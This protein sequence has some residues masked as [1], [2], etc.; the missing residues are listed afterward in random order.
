MTADPYKILGVSRTATADE[1]KQAFRR[2]ARQHHP[3]HNGGGKAAEERF[4]AVSIAHDLLSDPGKRAR[5][6]R[7]G[8][9]D[10]T[11][12]SSKKQRYHLEE[13]LCSGDLTDVH[14][15]RREADG[16]LVVLKIA[17]DPSVNDLVEREAKRLAHLFPLAADPNAPQVRYLPKF[18]ETF[19]ADDG[20]RRQVNV[21][22]FLANY[23]TCERLR[24]LTGGVAL[25]HGVWMFNRILEGLDYVHRCGFVHGALVPS[26]IMV[27]TDPKGHL[28]KLIDWG[29]AGKIHEP[30]VA[31]VPSY[32]D[33]Y[34]PE[35]AKKK[36]LGPETDLYMAAKML[37]YM[38]ADRMPD[39]LRTF[40]APC[41]RPEPTF[42]PHDAW[43][44]HESFKA[45]MH[46][47]YGPKKFVPFDNP[48]WAGS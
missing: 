45:H 30:A 19:K 27:W 10:P 22:D 21:L 41:L 48:A 5:Y 1:I 3:D 44:L 4:K 39:Y 34:P 7:L 9:T 40:L 20:K 13:L 31:M 11:V 8:T 29:Y 35:V 23:A 24:Q 36:P 15:A 28:V 18:W 6:D 32:G 37:V 46:R 16:R 14:R 43:A 33:F 12:L 38:L 47:H 2:L 26:H 17:R 25:E 42:R